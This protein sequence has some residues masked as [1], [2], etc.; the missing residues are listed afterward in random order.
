[1]T[2]PTCTSTRL[3]PRRDPA[4]IDWTSP[5][6]CKQACLILFIY[7]EDLWSHHN[8]L[9]VISKNA[10]VITVLTASWRFSSFIFHVGPSLCG[11]TLPTNK[12]LLYNPQQSLSHLKPWTNACGPWRKK[13]KKYRMYVSDHF[14]GCY[15]VFCIWI[16]W[17]RIQHFLAEYQAG[18]GSRVFM[19]K[20][21][22]EK[23]LQLQKKFD[24]FLIKKL[25]F[26]CP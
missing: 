3:S 7:L 18:S 26:T 8:P 16:H 23:N 1:M 11:W 12:V 4:F 20:N 6:W 24:I 22:R 19:T 17:F 21:W 25:Q 13:Q 14:W 2:R 9:F 5:L 10:L 15:P